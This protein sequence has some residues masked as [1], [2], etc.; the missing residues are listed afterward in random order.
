MTKYRLAAMLYVMYLLPIGC[1]ATP[2][3]ITA[4][5][6]D[7]A[8]VSDQKETLVSVSPG[9]SCTIALDDDPSQV[10]RVDADD[11]GFLH[12]YLPATTAP[13]SVPLGIITCSNA[14]GTTS[15]YPF[16][17]TATLARQ[18]EYQQVAA[19]PPP[20]STLRPAISGDPTMLSQGEIVAQ[21]FPP[22]PDRNTNPG[23]YASWLARASKPAWQL[24]PHS[25]SHPEISFLVNFNN[26]IWSGVAINEFTNYMEIT[27]KFPQPPVP[28]GLPIA[29]AIAAFW[30][31][32]DAWQSH[33]DIAQTGTLATSDRYWSTY[34]TW[35]VWFPTPTHITNIVVSPGDQM[36]FVEW[37]GDSVGNPGLSG[38]FAWSEIENNT[39]NVF[40]F[41]Q[42]AEPA[43]ATP[44]T[45]AEWI[46]EKPFVG[47]SQAPWLANYGTVLFD[48]TFAF[49]TQWISHNAQTDLGA[50]ITMKNGT[51]VE[52]TPVNGPGLA[53]VSFT[54]NAYQ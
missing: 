7:L 40:A 48:N 21:G 37:I 10:S 20:N 35:N 50:L 36:E 23:A 17:L 18:A 49:D 47:N 29:G 27:G 46:V 41:F 52:S 6:E 12:I 14:D 33:Q 2:S 8:A 31:G 24:R 53:E 25:V 28:A 26:N 51:D 16:N 32:L 34:Q 42:M 13:A 39:T 1:G 5:R 22:R 30:I 19:Q 11:F 9:A 44:G 43:G 4:T 15:N 3:N 38:G 45:S 54:W